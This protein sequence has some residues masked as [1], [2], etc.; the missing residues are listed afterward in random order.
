[1]YRTKRRREKRG[2]GSSTGEVEDDGSAPMAQVGY[3]R[4]SFTVP[5]VTQSVNQ[6]LKKEKMGRQNFKI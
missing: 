1:M 6:L 3:T 2:G 5:Y 4:L